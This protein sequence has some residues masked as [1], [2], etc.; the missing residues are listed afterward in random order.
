MT[1]LA[2]LKAQAQ[3]LKLALAEMGIA[4]STGQSLEAVAKQYGQPNWDTVAGM[5]SKRL[6]PAAE[7]RLADMPYVPSDIRVDDGVTS[8]KC[9]V[10]NYDYEAL[11]LLH[12][13]VALHSFIAAEPACYEKGMDSTAIFLFADGHDHHLTFNQLLGLK[14]CSSEV[15]SWAMVDGR[16]LQFYCDDVWEPLDVEPE[17][18]P[19]LTVPKMVKSVKGC[20]L[21]VLPSNDSPEFN[22][23]VLVPPHLDATKIRDQL[24][25]ELLRLKQMARVDEEK[26]NYEE[27]MD[28]ALSAFAASLGCL[29]MQEPWKTSETWDK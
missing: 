21:V 15:G 1:K 25:S 19:E 6:A 12:D 13:E 3:N 11:V 7:P 23:H 17:V 8:E 20:N 26:P 29:L 28:T 14:H 10:E 18:G 27:Y 4:L 24:T 16:R 5:L 2:S 9:V 22:L